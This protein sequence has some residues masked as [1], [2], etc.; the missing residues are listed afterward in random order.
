MFQQQLLIQ[1]VSS[2]LMLFVGF[3]NGQQRLV[4]L[5]GRFQFAVDCSQVVE[6]AG[7]LGRP[8]KGRVIVQ[9]QL[10]EDF[11]DA[12]ELLQARGSGDRGTKL[13][14]YLAEVDGS[15]TPGSTDAARDD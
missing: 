4:L 6:L 14:T 11:V 10:A 13:L 5:A 1:L 12:V 9:H 8:V 3:C 15:A 2:A 7:H